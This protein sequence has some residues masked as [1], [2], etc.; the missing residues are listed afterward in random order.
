MSKYTFTKEGVWIGTLLIVVASF[1]STSIITSKSTVTF[2][3]FSVLEL[4]LRRKRQLWTTCY[5]IIHTQY[6]F[7]NSWFISHSF[8]SNYIP[9]KWDLMSYI[10]WHLTVS[11]PWMIW[12]QKVTQRPQV[13]W[14]IT[15]KALQQSENDITSTRT[16]KIPKNIWHKHV[17]LNT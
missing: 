17:F 15:W 1:V 5:I 8:S 3:Y 10:L 9:L 11:Q 6:L 2:P 16:V 13:A 12:Q 4:H 14:L 7:S